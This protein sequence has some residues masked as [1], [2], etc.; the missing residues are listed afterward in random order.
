MNS[1]TLHRPVLILCCALFEIL[2]LMFALAVLSFSGSIV[3]SIASRRLFRSLLVSW[4]HKTN[5]IETIDHF[6]DADR[7]SEW[8]HTSCPLP[9][10]LA[11]WGGKQQVAGQHLLFLSLLFLEWMGGSFPLTLF[12]LVNKI[13]TIKNHISAYHRDVDDIRIGGLYMFRWLAL[14]HT[15]RMQKSGWVWVVLLLDRVV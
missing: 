9:R 4:F 15:F 14:H 13:Q 12:S 11:R 10:S 3:I 8:S 7:D 2:C 5:R 1:V 6:I